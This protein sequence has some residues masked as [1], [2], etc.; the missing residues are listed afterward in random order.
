[1]FLAQGREAPCELTGLA[2]A[3]GQFPQVRQQGDGLVVPRGHLG[4][5][6]LPSLGPGGLRVLGQVIQAPLPGRFALPLPQGL[7]GGGLGLGLP[8]ALQAEFRGRTRP[9][10]GLYPLRVPS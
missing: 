1:M 9:D 10:L 6:Q 4:A 5:D 7:P 3:P 2:A 8:V